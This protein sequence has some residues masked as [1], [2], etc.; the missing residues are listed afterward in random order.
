MGDIDCR[1][2]RG[3]TAPLPHAL[4]IQ[5]LRHS[6]RC[7]MSF[8]DVALAKQ[9]ATVGSTMSSGSRRCWM[10]WKHYLYYVYAALSASGTVTCSKRR[11]ACANGRVLPA[12]K[13]AILT[14]WPLQDA[15]LSPTPPDH[16]LYY[17]STPYSVIGSRLPDLL[18]YLRGTSSR[19]PRSREHPGANLF[20]IQ[21]L[22]PRERAR[23]TVGLTGRRPPLRLG[24]GRSR[25]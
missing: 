6:S 19:G 4:R 8:S 12:L 7:P 24:V 3:S 16:V 18:A 21:A 25:R 23:D 9:D 14:L 1:G 10:P 22:R 5:K 20:V 2:L 11:V 15:G 13:V 17:P